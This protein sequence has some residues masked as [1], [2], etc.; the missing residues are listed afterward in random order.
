MPSSRCSRT[1]RPTSCALLLVLLIAVYGDAIPRVGQHERKASRWWKRSVADIV[2]ESDP[3]RSELLKIVPVPVES[4]G[5]AGYQ[6][7]VDRMLGKAE[8]VELEAQE[9]WPREMC[10]QLPA[11]NVSGLFQ[12]PFG[13]G[14]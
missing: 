8:R 4:E 7:F 9:F 10:D 12:S 14:L 11:G 13:T 6:G 2:V 3:P 1:I 5:L